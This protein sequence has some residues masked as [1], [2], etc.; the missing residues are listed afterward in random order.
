MSPLL[1]DTPVRLRQEAS[2]DYRMPIS[3]TIRAGRMAQRV[4]YWGLSSGPAASGAQGHACTCNPAL[5]S[6][7]PKIAGVL[8]AASL[9]Y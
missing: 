2:L 5:G 4:E 3:E 9:A 7:A 8:Q 6:R 1:W